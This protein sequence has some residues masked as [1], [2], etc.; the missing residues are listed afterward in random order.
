MEERNVLTFESQNKNKPALP[1]LGGKFVII[2]FILS[3]LP[4]TYIFVDVFGGGANVVY[5]KPLSPVTVYNDK[6]QE[7]YNFFKVLREQYDQLAH[8]L[9]YTPFSYQLLKE[10]YYKLR[11]SQEP[12]DDLH[13]AWYFFVLIRQSFAS[14][15]DSTFGYEFKD[16]RKPKAFLNAVK[17]L[18]QLAL[19]F[20]KIYIFNLDY[21]DI[22]LKYDRPETLFYLDPPYI[23]D[24]NKKASHKYFHEFTFEQHCELVQFI[25]TIKAKVCVSHYKHPL[26]EQELKDWNKRYKE[27]QIPKYNDRKN[28]K[29]ALK[30]EALYMNY[31]VEKEK[32]K[33]NA[34]ISSV[35]LQTRRMSKRQRILYLNL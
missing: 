16:G 1:Y 22:M 7:V 13:R 10:A 8:L 29:D 4:Q 35:K 31:D 5:N 3:S 12:L 14:K 21:K 32:E 6:A 18:E 11:V 19:F 28:K 33:E 27:R 2:D 24:N 20:K 15:G 26:Y 25:K 17:N 23:L 9:K 34:I 30:I